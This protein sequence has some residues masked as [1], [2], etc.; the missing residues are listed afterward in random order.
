MS[1]EADK[2]IMQ[3]MTMVK[4]KNVCVWVMVIVMEQCV[5]GGNGIAYTGIGEEQMLE[6]IVKHR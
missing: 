6:M 5:Y 1:D 3:I 4:E 2:D